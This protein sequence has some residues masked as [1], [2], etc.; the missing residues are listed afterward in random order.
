Q[1]RPWIVSLTVC[2]GGTPVWG[3]RPP[4]NESRQG[5]LRSSALTRF[6]CCGVCHN[7][8]PTAPE[9]RR[10]PHCVGPLGAGRSVVWEARPPRNE[11]RQG[12]RRSSALTRFGCCGVCHNTPPTAPEERRRPHCVGPL[13]A[14]R[15]VVWG[16][17][18]P[19]NESRQGTRRSSALTRFGCCG[20]C[21]NTPP[22]APEE[23]RRP[24]FV[25]PRVPGR[26][27]VWGARPPPTVAE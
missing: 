24:H 17:R 22:T 12:T 5:T 27:G 4:R 21:H 23:R 20:V 16:A 10:R 9:E 15:S 13:G 3:A 26:S 11:S 14:G 6:G 18:P 1:A 19:R 7:T 8:P 2:L 25:G